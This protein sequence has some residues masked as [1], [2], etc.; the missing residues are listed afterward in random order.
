MCFG[1][2]SL[3]NQRPGNHSDKFRLNNNQKV[4]SNLSDWKKDWYLSRNNIWCSIGDKIRPQG[5]AEIQYY[6]NNKKLKLRVTEE[7]Y[8]QRLQ[9]ISKDINI[10]INELSSKT[11]YSSCRMKARFIEISN[12]EFCTK[13]QAKILQAINNNQS[14]SAKII[15]KLSPNGKDVGFYLQLSFEESY[16][17]VNP[18]NKPNTMGIDLNQKG[19]AYCI[20][21]SDGNKLNYNKSNNIQYKPHGFISWDLE[22]KTTEQREWIISNK[23]TELLT[24]AQSFGI[25]SIAIENLDF[26]STINNMNS[27]YK[28][29]QKYNKMLTQ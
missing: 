14:I 21:K 12:V 20:I 26:S 23:I 22:D 15:K 16:Q 7:T 1:S 8:L 11:K 24:I 13:N 6:P 25:N 4:Y 9:Q 3:L 28:T 27:G 19:L 2:S 18:N 10:P 17:Q 5:N 29:N